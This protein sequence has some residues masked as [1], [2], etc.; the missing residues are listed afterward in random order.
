MKNSI[1]IPLLFMLLLIVPAP[2]AVFLDDSP[3]LRWILFTAWV[4]MVVLFSRVLQ[5]R[6]MAGLFAMDIDAVTAS[7]PA[8]RG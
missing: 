7:H 2:V 5:R 8:S 3:W 1:V 6:G 4:A